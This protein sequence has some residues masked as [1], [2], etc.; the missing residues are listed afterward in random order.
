MEQARGLAVPQIINDHGD[1]CRDIG[2]HQRRPKWCI[3]A[4]W[5]HIFSQ[6]WKN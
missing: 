5:F 4:S 1:W 3:Y 2:E 6:Y